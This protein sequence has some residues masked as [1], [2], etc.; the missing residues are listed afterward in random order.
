MISKK[1]LIIIAISL[2]IA[3]TLAI[4]FDFEDENEV[5]F[6][7]NCFEVEIASSE[8]ELTKG[9]MHKLNLDEDSGMLFVFEEEGFYQFWMKDMFIPLDMI[10]ISKDDEIIHIEKNVQPCS[11]ETCEIFIPNEKALYVLE[12][13]SGISEKIGLEI[14][15]TADVDL[16]I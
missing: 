4:S 11:Q 9:L 13:N 10:W 14:G 7:K 2:L 3:Y 5:C 12:I 8:E 15:Q 16:E 1:N 6:D